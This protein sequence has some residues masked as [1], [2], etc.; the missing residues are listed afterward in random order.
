M[1]RHISQIVNIVATKS[2]FI[3]VLV[4]NATTDL[5]TRLVNLREIH[6]VARN[7]SYV[8]KKIA[9]RSIIRQKNVRTR[10]SDSTIDTL[11][12]KVAQNTIAI[13]DNTSLTTKKMIMTM[14]TMLF[15]SSKICQSTHQKISHQST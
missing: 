6:L 12:T 13:Y 4:I 10:R 7:A 5:T 15:T 14:R 9:D 1:R 11:N 3:F 8:T 2:N